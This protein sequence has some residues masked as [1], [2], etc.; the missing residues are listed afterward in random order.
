MNLLEK[1]QKKTYALVG[2]RIGHY[3]ITPTIKNMK[4]HNISGF[5]LVDFDREMNNYK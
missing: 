1:T 4:K 3:P 5:F 2:A